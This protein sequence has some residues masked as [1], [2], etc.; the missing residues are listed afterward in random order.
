MTTNQGAQGLK[1]KAMTAISALLV[2]GTLSACGGNNNAAENAQGGDS[3]AP[4]DE[5]PFKMS[6]MLTSYNPE[7]MDPEG[8]LYKRLEERT[9][10]DLSITWVP[11]TT[12]SDKLSATVA[13]GE[14]PSAVLVLDQKLPY[15]VNSARSG[16]FWELGPYLKDYPNLSR[17][18]DVA[19]NA[20]SIDGKIY[21][22]YRARDLA[23]DGLM[24]RKD[25]L[26]N[27]GLQEPKTID[28]F[29][30]V[31]KAFVNNDPDK[32]GK[33]D[34]IGLAEQQ[35]ASGWRAMLTWMGGPA[36]WEIK[37]GKASPAHLSPAFLE[38][39]KFYKK[40]YDEKLINLDFAVVKDGK[41]M[42][43]A[44][45]AGAWVANLNDAN[46]IEES[47]QKVTPSGAITMVNALEGP[48]GLRSPG[49]SGSYGIFMIPKTSVKT[50]ADL[51]AVLNFFDKVSDEDMQNMLVNGLEGRQFTLDN[52]NYVKTTDPKMLAEYGM[53]DSSQ[54]AVLRDKVVT[55]GKPLVHL[56]DEMW[57]KNAEIAV[58]NPIQPFISDTYSERGSE[59]SK[60]IDDARVRFIMGDLDESGWNAA[61][62]K[63]EQDGGAKVIEEYTAAYN[64]ANGQ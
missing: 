3:G 29:Y 63:W 6:M 38:T 51:K 30:E 62:A 26:D 59:L 31:L 18:D 36:D 52:G 40:L 4:A 48:A 1:R 49:G 58:V 8:E 34:T 16:M 17:M 32:N 19:L 21:G 56:R 39:M 35:V 5:G 43:N 11:S 33:A 2:L 10:T 15:I 23:R 60:I 50:E 25:W 27:L 14:L 9:N 37:D 61:V 53:G 41:Q 64:Q 57:K 24:L 20:I 22:I 12:Y 7:P 45:K 55:Y 42:I 47:V 46:G 13:S 44:G 28:E 54:L